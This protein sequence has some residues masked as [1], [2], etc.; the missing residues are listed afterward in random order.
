MKECTERLWQLET[1]LCDDGDILLAQGECG[2][3][4]EV[5]VRLHRSQIP[6]VA[7]LGGFVPADD[8]ARATERLQDR[9]GLVVSLVRSHCKPDDPLRIVVDALLGDILSKPLSSPLVAPSLP[10]VDEC[11]PSAPVCASGLRVPCNADLFAE[12]EGGGNG[13]EA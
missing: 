4:D 2:C 12:S 7:K 11:L 8:V 3:G 10:L 13:Q 1:M 6:L 9:L 5:L